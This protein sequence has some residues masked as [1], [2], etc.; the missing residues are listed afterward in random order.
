ML[1]PAWEFR[2]SPDESNLRILRGPCASRSFGDIGM[3][4][5]V[6]FNNRLATL[7]GAIA[8]TLASGASANPPASSLSLL[9]NVPAVGAVAANDGPAGR[10][11]PV[12]IHT[13][14]MARYTVVLKEEPVATYD[15]LTSGYAKIPL[16]RKNRADM[17]SAEAVKYAG[18]LRDRQ[19]QFL[20]VIG[21]QLKRPVDAILQFQHA[22][23]G[24]V[25]ELTAQEAAEVAAR[26]DVLLVDIEKMQPLLTNRSTFFIGAD[27]IWDGSATGGLATQ[28]EGIVIG[29][30]DSGINFTSPSFASPGPVDGYVYTNPL[31][32]GNY[33]GLCQSGKADEGHCTDKLIGL[34]DFVYSICSAGNSCG[35]AGTWVD[36]ASATDSNGHGSH[37]AS[38]AAGNHAS[39][40]LSGGDFTISGVAPHASLV[41]YDVCYTRVSDGS[42]LCPTTSTTNAANQAVA[43]GVVDILTF[44]IGGGTSPWTDTTS[45]A[46]RGAQNAGI[47]VVAAAG[48]DGPTAATVSH[49]EPWVATAAAST[50]DQVFGYTFNLNGPGTPPANTVNLPARPGA[51]PQPTGDLVNLPIT[52]SPGFANGNNDGC[53][54][55]ADPHTFDR[56]VTASE[57]IFA[58]GFEGT[59]PASIYQKGIAVL[60]LDGNNSGCGSG[61]RRGN[62]LNAGA[63]GVIYI[64]TAYLN[65]GASDTSYSMTFDEWNPV[66]A[67][68]STDPANATASLLLPL[69][70]YLT[71]QGDVIADFS[72][73]GPN[74]GLSGQAIVKPELAAPGVAILAAYM[75]DPGAVALEDGTS[76]STPHIAGSAALLRALHPEWTPTQIRS[77]MMLTAKTDGVVK[78][79]NTPAGIWER[80]A[81]RIDLAAAAKASLTL[82][83]TT[84]NYIA[85]NPSTGGKISTLNLP[86]IADSSCIAACT[87]S[88]T[89]K[90]VHAG[91]VTYTLSVDGFPTG[92]ASVSPTSLA[93]STGGTKTFTVTVQGD[94]LTP[95]QYTLGQVTLTPS[96]PSIPVQHMPVA[97]Q[98]S[99]PIIQLS[100]NAI[101]ASQDVNLGPTTKPLTVTNI[102]NPTLNWVVGG[103]VTGT[104]LNTA[105]SGSGYP[106]GYYPVLPD[107]VFEAQAFDVTAPTH[108]TSLRA[109]GFVNPS[110]SLTTSN[111]TQVTFS[112]FADASSAPDGIPLGLGGNPPVWTYSA[113]VNG[114]GVSVPG[115]ALALNLNAAGVP[116]LNLTGGRYWFVAYPTMNTNPPYAG[117]GGA[118]W[119]WRVSTDTPNNAKPAIIETGDP[120]W[121]ITT[122]NSLSAQIQGSITCVQPS[123]VSY[124]PTSDALGYNASSNVTVTFDPTGL[125]PGNYS[126]KLCISS[127]AVNTATAVVDLAFAVTGTLTHTVTPSVGTDPSW[128]TIDPDT[129]QTVN[130][131]ATTQF[132][133]S[134]TSGHHVDTVGGTCGGTLDTDTNVY[135]TNAVTADCSVIANFAVD[136][137]THKVTP[138]VGTD[139]SWGTIDPD[140]QQTVNDGAT[141]QFTLS[142]TSGHHV[143]TVGGTCGGTLDTDTNVYTTNAVTADCS[144]VAN[145]ASD[146]CTTGSPVEVKA[147]AG[148]SG[149]TGYST[150][151]DA[152]DAINAG[153]HQGTIAVSICGD[154]TEAASA[155]LNA[156]GSGSA[157]YTTIAVHPDGG[158][159]RTVSGAITAGSPLVDLNGADNVTIDGL[160]SGGNALTLSNTTASVTAGTSTIRFIEGASNNTITN[161]TIQGSATGAVTTSTGTVLFSTSTVPG[162]NS[163]NTVSNNDIGP[164]GSNLP[165][166]TVTGLGTSGNSNA[167]NVIDGNRIHD[168]FSATTTSAGVSIQAN[169]NGWTVSNNRIYQTAARTFTSSATRYAG[170]SI[171]STGNSYTVSGNTI[172]FGAADGTGT[173]T[174]TGTSNEIRGIDITDVSTTVVTTVANNVISGINQTSSRAST[175]V[176]SA[177]FMGI[178]LGTSFSGLFNVTGNTIGSLDGSSTIVVNASS[179]SSG[180]APLVGI[181]DYADQGATIANNAIGAITIQQA[182]GAGT[183]TGFQGIYVFPAAT[184]VNTITNNTVGGSTAAGAI[185]DNLTGL[186]PMW[187]I[188]ALD[189]AA[190]ASGNIVQNYSGKS[191]YA[192]ATNGIAMGGLQLRS[193]ASSGAGHVAN[194]T[195]RNLTNAGGAAAGQIVGMYANLAPVGNVIEKNVVDALVGTS[196]AVYQTIGIAPQGSN[197]GTFQNNLVR[198]GLDAAGNGLTNAQLIAGIGDLGGTNSYYYNDVYVG[199]SGVTTGANSYAFYST[200]TTTRNYQNNVFWNARGN[201][202]AGG[203]AH[204]AIRVGGTTP[205]PAGLTSDHNILLATGT[206]GVTGFFNSAIVPTLADWQTATGQD[207]TSI[208][209]DPL[210][211]APTAVPFDLHVQTGSPA[212]GAGTPIVAV[213]DDYDG[214]ARS[215]TTPTI[216]AYE[217]AAA[218]GG[219]NTSSGAIPSTGKTGV[220]S[221]DA[222]P[223][224]QVDVVLQRLQQN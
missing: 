134:P 148:T 71:A 207:A 99:G 78:Q 197:V 75:G 2:K 206:D 52:Q 42:G 9:R 63:A 212:I 210:F 95:G 154:T 209:A 12:A 179:T 189:G 162:G 105:T 125:T 145:F 151:K 1:G 18:Y 161:A 31:G 22:I 173:T 57:R 54:A 16:G 34:Y 106:G 72:S 136:V 20:S 153:T 98:P 74:A 199:G 140:T 141:T 160:N 65:L 96:D 24:V 107:G 155:V 66:Y 10:Q 205:N 150:L 139:P 116:A 115:S 7:A 132:T 220:L 131:G 90:G 208:A 163:N 175:S 68:I 183:A 133:L 43:D 215:A 165:T 176:P 3:K 4:V 32:A 79:D 177:A 30:I 186:Y 192:I 191:T 147:D 59:T 5:R 172:G 108:V 167:G 122:A 92:S 117:G 121:S 101:A 224:P 51:N 19:N 100:T 25:V 86:S 48:N 166:K 58:D 109:N 171:T 111:T 164:A 103:S 142:P 40:S 213:T 190:N 67:Q 216:G 202:T 143:D 149:P 77:A 112:V 6:N 37:T 146:S 219:A 35:T 62:A 87:Y 174:I 157:S 144:V 23:N 124:S 114:S 158:A 85:A 97:I 182:A 41:A 73:R 47:F 81:G 217:G 49:I 94:Q 70:S 21:T 214:V 33:L 118:G 194:N 60:H 93:V 169:N 184:A 69:K 180:T 211:V 80:G 203:S 91:A 39:V 168:F 14:G 200:V 45:L 102:G 221:N 195:V 84:A 119:Y 222:A 28:G 152:F 196:S 38:T 61:V 36:E 46:F 126:G 104:I 27:K 88:R 53:S 185:K 15:G 110:G 204:I 156:S 159:A 89:V 17:H 198:L 138:S 8:I 170:I 76:M 123:W 223:L 129:Q 181:F 218:R 29:D 127:N 13:Q 188:T 135:T 120:S 130:D 113:A 193:T 55:F 201:T 26:D 83:E 11:M 82:D 44:S 64:D 128:G 56:D 178:A 187:G 50:D 137:V